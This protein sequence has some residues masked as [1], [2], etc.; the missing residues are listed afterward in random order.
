M[1]NWVGP[2]K[3]KVGDKAQLTKVFSKEDVESFAHISGD[4]NPIHLDELFSAKT[5]FGRCI[6]HGMLVSGL[7]SAVLG[8]HLPGPGSIYLSQELRF[9]RPVYIED[10]ITALVEVVSIREDKPIVTLKTLCVNQAG[11]N[12]IE[13]IAVL[14]LA[15]C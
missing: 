1:T 15:H 4:Y 13:G 12:V 9:L 14:L 3:I 6:V 2:A 8:M 10:T 11:Q 5:R 7:I